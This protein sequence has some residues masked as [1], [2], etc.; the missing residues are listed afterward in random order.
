MNIDEKLLFFVRDFGETGDIS[1]QSYFEEKREIYLEIGSGKG[2]FIAQASAQKP[3]VNFI[4]IEL[5]SRR[6]TTI[7]KKLDPEI[8]SN[9]K[10]FRSYVTT[11]FMNRFPAESIDRI[12]VFHPDP[13]PKKRH[14]KKRL[15][16]TDFLDALYKVLKSDGEVYL[17][18]DFKDYA[19]W[20][21][22]HFK[23]NDG[24]ASF[25]EEGY[26]REPYSEHIETY[27]E[28]KHK[29]LGAPPY[30]MRYKKILIGA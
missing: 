9:V 20:I 5:K 21:I 17:S 12:Y 26:S 19:D 10:L 14:Y 13:W 24:F 2:E 16:Q 27:F 7:S 28:I 22:D 30:Y 8:N 15:I 6:I 25:Y 4:G 23:A 1:P 29:K 11:E 18:T 3:N